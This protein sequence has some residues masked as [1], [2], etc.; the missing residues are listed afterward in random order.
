MLTDGHTKYSHAPV[1]IGSVSAVS[2]T[3]S[4]PWPPKNCKIKEI[5]GSKVLKHA[6]SE[7][8]P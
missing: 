7:K 1:S 4:L 2:V 3:R 6:P 8:G 5:N